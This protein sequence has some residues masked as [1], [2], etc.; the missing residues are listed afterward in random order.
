M[1]IAIIGCGWVGKKLAEYLTGKGHEIIA[2]TTSPDKIQELKM[3]A[4]EVQLLDFS[5][6]SKPKFLNDTDVAI[7]SMPISRSSWFKGFEKMEIVFPKTLLFS[8]TGIYPQENRIFTEKDTNNLRP[9]IDA[10]EQLVRKKY[11]QTNILRFGGLMGDER[12]VQHFFKNKE[13]K[14]PEK[15]VNYIHYGDILAM[16]ELVI[17]SDKTSRIYNIVAPE[18][19]SIGEILSL[20]PENKDTH[21]DES[22]QRIISS[23]L[24]VNEFNYDFKHPNPQ[25]FNL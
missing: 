3:A 4:A 18:H 7:F 19:P 22:A 1:K 15:R 6:D 17:Q 23:E 5:K 12:S 10:A 20:H 14:N 25:Y 9:D 16:V 13:V 11:P 8:S 24:F 2:T 21:S